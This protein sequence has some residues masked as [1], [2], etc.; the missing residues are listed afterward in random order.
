MLLLIKLKFSQHIK[1][2][3]RRNKG[4]NYTPR[5]FILPT[6]LQENLYTQ[7]LYYRRNNGKIYTPRTYKSVKHRR[8]RET[9]VENT[10]QTAETPVFASV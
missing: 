2:A 9:Y 3:R 5:K 1:H 10:L 7:N 8:M 4:K 6:K